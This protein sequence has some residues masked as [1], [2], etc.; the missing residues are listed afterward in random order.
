MSCRLTEL[1]DNKTIHQPILILFMSHFLSATVTV[2]LQ[3]TAGRS[4]WTKTRLLFP[5]MRFILSSQGF[6]CNISQN[7]DTAKA[8]NSLPN[9]ETNKLMSLFDRFTGNLRDQIRVCIGAK[10][11]SPPTAAMTS[12]KTSLTAGNLGHSDNHPYV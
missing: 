11:A 12:A 3:Q 1:K 6:L 8:Q 7:V 2:F 10:Q 4:H 9:G 5:Y